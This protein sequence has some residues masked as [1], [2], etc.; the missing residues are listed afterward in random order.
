MHFYA[1]VCC[2]AWKLPVN[3]KMTEFKAEWSYVSLHATIAIFKP[4]VM[5]GFQSPPFGILQALLGPVILKGA[6]EI[7]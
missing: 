1:H 6:Y 3:F 2:N 4:E 7:V 5:S